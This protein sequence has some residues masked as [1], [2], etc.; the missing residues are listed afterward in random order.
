MSALPTVLLIVGLLAGA[1]VGA[2]VCAAWYR[3]R[4]A[5]AV[6]LARTDDLTG[7]GNR[8]ALLADLA[9]ALND[10]GPSILMLLDLDGFKAVNDT[11]GHGVGDQVLQVV[12]ARLAEYLGAGCPLARLG[13]DEFAALIPDDDPVQLLGRARRLRIDISRPIRLSST[14]LTVPASIGIG[15][16][17]SDDILPTDLLRRADQALYQAKTGTGIA[18]EPIQVPADPAGRGCGPGSGTSSASSQRPGP[19]DRVGR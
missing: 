11:H 8:R 15:L 17:S 16:P 7:L 5:E 1:T 3:Q 18:L 12:A 14:T 4:L 10:D 6:R 13:G 19:G 9:R 2:G